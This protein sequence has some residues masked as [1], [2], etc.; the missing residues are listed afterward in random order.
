[1]G[2]REAKRK[3]PTTIASTQLE[4]HHA[5][6]TNPHTQGDCELRKV[7]PDAMALKFRE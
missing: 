1:M 7:D 4:G 5:P 3:L 2:D 6:P